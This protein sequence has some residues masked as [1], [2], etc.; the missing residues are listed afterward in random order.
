MESSDS[1][2]TPGTEDP[3]TPVGPGVDNVPPP[4]PDEDPAARTDEQ[5][6]D[7]D[8]TPASQDAP[9]ED[10]EQTPLTPPEGDVA[11]SVHRQAP[12][13][14]EWQSGDA[15]PADTEQD[16]APVQT[17]GGSTDGLSP[18]TQADDNV[19]DEGGDPNPDD[20]DR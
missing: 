2:S 20:S 12:A 6:A 18:G 8:P 17:A 1:P 3:Q 13:P 9:A 10:I 16:R 14:P 19:E 4:A 7:H 5:E 15:S 11:N